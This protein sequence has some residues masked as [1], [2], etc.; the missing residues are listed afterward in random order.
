MPII[1][2]A[3]GQ[4][5]AVPWTSMVIAANQIKKLAIFIGFWSIRAP[6][7]MTDM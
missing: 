6:P 1:I 3:V 4:K 5:F 7:R 2:V